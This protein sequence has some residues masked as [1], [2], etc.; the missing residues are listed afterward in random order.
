VLLLAI[1]RRKPHTEHFNSLALPFIV[2][3]SNSARRTMST[4]QEER[5]AFSARL[6]AACQAAGFNEIGAT[7]LQTEFNLRSPDQV[8]IHAARKW[9][10]CGAIPVQSRLRVLATWLQV[11]IDWLRFG[12]GSAS[13]LPRADTQFSE[14][15]YR[16]LSALQKLNTEHRHIVDELI[17]HLVQLQKTNDAL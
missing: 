4:S 7:R 14:Q 1:N 11:P 15:N 5:A 12:N 6:V 2:L 17:K 10:I 8:T 16:T 3:V 13:T 9:L